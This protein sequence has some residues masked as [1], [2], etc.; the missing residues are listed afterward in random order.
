MQ[1]LAVSVE[2]AAR[3]LGL[4][5]HTVRA[6]IRRGL[7]PATHLGRRVVVRMDSLETILARG[8][9]D[10]RDGPEEK[11]GGKNGEAKER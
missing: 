4:S 3:L 10:G 2:E 9:S 1:P 8:L 6:Y 11:K 5:K 7:I